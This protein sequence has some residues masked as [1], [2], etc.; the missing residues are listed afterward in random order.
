MPIPF[1]SQLADLKRQ[2]VMESHLEDDNSN[3]DDPHPGELDDDSGTRGPDTIPA[4]A[5]SDGTRTGG[6]P[7][8]SADG[9]QTPGGDPAQSQSGTVDEEPNYPEWFPDEFRVGRES[10]PEEIRR[11]YYNLTGKLTSPDFSRG[12]VDRHRNQLLSQRQEIEDFATHFQAFKNNPREYLKT[13]MPDFYQEIGIT[14]RSEDE[15]AGEVNKR[16]VEEFGDRWESFFDAKDAVRPGTPSRKMHLRSLQIEQELMDEN[17]RAQQTI[18]QRRQALAEQ[19]Q[20]EQ[21]QQQAPQVTKENAFEMTW[22][23]VKEEF[24]KIGVDEAAYKKFIDEIAD[25]NINMLDIYRATNYARDIEQA[26]ERGRVEGRKALSKE[27]GVAYR[28]PEKPKEPEK[29]APKSDARDEFFKKQR[30]IHHQ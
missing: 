10:T 14:V 21:Q 26:V 1:L 9:A 12:F 7:Q 27:L 6:T 28:A 3:I 18:A 19:A 20:M 23:Q 8:G 29:K 17:N 5:G 2:E 16:M 11:A 25:R 30:R 24:Q 4:T 22:P 15:I 13:W